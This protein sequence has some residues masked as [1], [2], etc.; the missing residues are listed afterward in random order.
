MTTQEEI[1]L[2]SA[3]IA[4]TS[5]TANVLMGIT[6]NRLNRRNLKRDEILAVLRSLLQRLE[7][8]R[9]FEVDPEQEI[10]EFGFESI[11]ELALQIAPAIVAVKS[12][13]FTDLEVRTSVSQ[14]G[15]HVKALRA[16]HDSWRLFRH[17]KPEDWRSIQRDWPDIERARVALEAAKPVAV[18]CRDTVSSFLGKA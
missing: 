9:L 18:Q 4:A 8:T 15:D 14:L 17:G 7:Y 2:V 13:K 10:W 3:A 5:L 12:S 11:R 16:F 1:S 6:I